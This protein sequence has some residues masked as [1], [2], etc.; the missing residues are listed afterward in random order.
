MLVEDGELRG[1]EVKPLTG[2]ANKIAYVEVG[3]IEFRGRGL[4]RG[5]A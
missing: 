2:L 1:C 4:S 3:L 5:G